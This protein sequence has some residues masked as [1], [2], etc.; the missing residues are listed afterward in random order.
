MRLA[1]TKVNGDQVTVWFRTTGQPWRAEGAEAVH[2][3][4]YILQEPGR[5]ATEYLDRRT[6]DALLPAFGF[7]ARRCCLVRKP[8]TAPSHL[9]E[10]RISDNH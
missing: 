2:I 6:G 3:D 10:G 8:G 5:A 1:A 7:V 4:R 9:R